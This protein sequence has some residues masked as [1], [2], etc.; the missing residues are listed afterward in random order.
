MIPHKDYKKVILTEN[1]EQG[2]NSIVSFAE[3]VQRESEND[4]GFFRWLF[5][6]YDLGD[7]ECP[8]DTAFES[9]LDEL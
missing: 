4:P 7:S 6:D 2:D 8:D 1:Y 3:W 5:E 9:F